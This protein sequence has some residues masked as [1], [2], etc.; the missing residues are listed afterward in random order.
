[1][2]PAR[3]GMPATLCQALAASGDALPGAPPSRPG[4]LERTLNC[5]CL[6]RPYK[7]QALRHRRDRKA[8]KHDDP[9]AQRD[10][11]DARSSNARTGSW[12]NLCTHTVCG[13]CPA[14]AGD[15]LSHTVHVQLPAARR[16]SG[17]RVRR[18]LMLRASG[19]QRMRQARRRPRKP[20]NRSR[21][22]P[23]SGKET[24]VG[25]AGFLPAANRLRRKEASLV[26]GFQ[27]P[28]FRFFFGRNRLELP[29]G[30]AC[31]SAAG[32]GREQEGRFCCLLGRGYSRARQRL[33]AAVPWKP[34]CAKVSHGVLWRTVAAAH[35]F[36][37][38]P[39]RG[40]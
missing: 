27:E 7:T 34:R 5:R 22:R 30:M 6:H 18:F 8:A 25:K 31:V 32:P 4:P 15:T 40:N 11:D 28:G 1:M 36:C 35:R 23:A 17:M 14:A 39:G 29:A 2:T 33:A 37:G 12:V 38:L 20:G 19:W 3:R 21:W 13:Q 24:P 16:V 26:S 10:S 9:M